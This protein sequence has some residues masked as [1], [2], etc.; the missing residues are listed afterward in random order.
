[1]SVE[2]QVKVKARLLSIGDHIEPRA[3]LI[4]DRNGRSIV[5][6]FTDIRRAKLV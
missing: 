5:L 1:V 4:T 6:H 2:A 3:Q